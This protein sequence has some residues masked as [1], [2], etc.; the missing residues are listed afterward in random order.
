MSSGG[1]GKKRLL[2]NRPSVRERLAQLDA[3][4]V[5]RLLNSRIFFCSSAF[6]CWVSSVGVGIMRGRSVS[7]GVGYGGVRAD[8]PKFRGALGLSGIA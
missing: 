5:V 1:F 3:H 2:S 6:C 4:G 7:G 8:A